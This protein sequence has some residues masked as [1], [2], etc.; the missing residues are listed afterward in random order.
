MAVNYTFNSGIYDVYPT[1]YGGK[2]TFVRRRGGGGEVKCYYIAH[3]KVPSTGNN[4]TFFGAEIAFV[5]E[6]IAETNV[7]S[8]RSKNTI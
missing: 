4:I 8:F 3:I 7:F 6:A 2:Y 5:L 1:P